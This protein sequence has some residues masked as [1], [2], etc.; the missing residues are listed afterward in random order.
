VFVR[1]SAGVYEV[2]SLSM[3]IYSRSLGM[4]RR[5]SLTIRT[6]ND[7]SKLSK[8]I[9]E[10]VFQDDFVKVLS[11]SSQDMWKGFAHP[12]VPTRQTPERV[13]R[14]LTRKHSIKP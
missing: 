6:R 11:N 2:K 5:L 12:I 7:T 1:E 4:H 14:V 3:R 9:K 8:V 13:F 10:Q